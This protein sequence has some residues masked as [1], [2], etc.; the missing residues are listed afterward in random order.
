MRLSDYTPKRRDRYVADRGWISTHDFPT[1]RL[2]L[3]AYSPYPL[4]EWT[5]AEALAIVG[6]YFHRTPASDRVLLTS[7]ALILGG[8]VGNLAD[9][10]LQGAVTDFID[11]YF[12]SYHWHTFN[13][14]DSAIT[15]GIAV[16]LL[17]SFRKAPEEAAEP[18]EAAA[19]P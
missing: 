11:F 14:A 13:I 2:C 1:G 19:E 4:A 10:V 3:Q 6:V 8:A 16:M 18:R 17:A 15:V 5:L 7:L 12:G 9:R